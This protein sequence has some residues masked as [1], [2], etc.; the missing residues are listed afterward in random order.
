LILSAFWVKKWGARLTPTIP[1]PISPHIGLGLLVQA[2]PR[3]HTLETE[4]R[5]P[6]RF[7]SFFFSIAGCT[8]LTIFAGCGP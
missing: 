1:N 5:A 6:E 8:P 3:M 4:D 2:A 7:L